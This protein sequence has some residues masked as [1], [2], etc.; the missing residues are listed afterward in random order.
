M[1][2]KKILLLG[3][4]FVA[5][6]CVEYL[7]RK[8]ENKIT[9]ASRRLENAQALSKKFPGTVAVSCDI[10][11]EQAIED[12]VAQHDVAISLIPYI[13]HAKV[14]KAAVKHKKNVVTTSY[15]SPAMM[16]YDQAAKDAGITVMNE[17]GLDPGIDHLYAVKTIEEVH[18]EGGKLK[19]FI[20]FCGGLPAPEDSNNPFGYKFSWSARG[21]LLALKNTAKYLENGKVVEVSGTALMDSAKKLNTGYPGFAFV[22]YGNRD[23]TPYDKRYNIPEAET[24]IRGTIRYDG[25]CQFVKALVILGFLSEEE[26]AHLSANAPEITWREVIAKVVGTNETSAEAL[27]AAIIAKCDLDNN[28]HKAQILDGMRWVGFF[29][30]VAVTRRGSLLDTFCATLEEKMQY[31]ENE[32]DLV[33]LQHRFEIELKDGTHQ[34]RT[35]TLLEYGKVG[36]YSAM[37]TT[38]GVPCGIA[39]QLVL[40]GKLTATGVLAPMSSEINEPII[41]LLEKEGIGMVEKIL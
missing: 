34:T 30:D 40:D 22:G 37:A 14:I 15:V 36:G 29:S 21:V 38:V 23:S 8:P 16:E 41:E 9:I 6:P 28:D 2:D 13:Y 3:S 19:E 32:R 39:T 24:I 18:R 25:F 27:Q 5:A 26:E 10:T 31:G 35:S 12:L 11:D 33:F 4:G 17:I 20:S 1:G 7:A